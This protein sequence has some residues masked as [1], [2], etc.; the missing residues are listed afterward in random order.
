MSVIQTLVSGHW[1][2]CTAWT[3][4]HFIWEG[5]AIAAIYTV[6]RDRMLCRSSSPRSRYVLACGALGAMAI[7]PL[8]TWYLI[9]RPVE[10]VSAD[11]S[12]TLLSRAPDSSVLSALSLYRITPASSGREVWVWVVALWFSVSVTLLTRTMGG[13][14]LAM[15]L[16]ATFARSAPLEWCER[17]A[18]LSMHVGLR[19]SLRLSISPIVNVPT[20]M[21]WLRPVVLV[22]V[23]F[24]TGLPR[25]QVEAVLLH[26]LAH[27]RRNDYLVNILQSIAEALLFYH[28]AVWW[29][30][31][32]IRTER[33]LCCD[34][35]AVSAGSD[36]FSYARAL[37]EL[38]LTG[39]TGL[40]TTL[41]VTGG[42][43]AE[44]IERLLALPRPLATP[45]FSKAGL[46]VTATLIAGACFTLF[47]SLHAQ[48]QPDWQIAAGGKMQFEVASVK[49][50]K[51]D[52]FSSLFPLSADDSYKSTGGRFSADFPLV[53]YVQFA[54]RLWMTPEQ[55]GAMLEQ[56][57]KWAATDH[58]AIEARAEGNPTKDQMRLM[59]QS[60][61]ADRFKLAM[62]FETRQGKVLAL[63]LVTTGKTGPGLRPHADGPQ[64]DNDGDPSTPL[65]PAKPTD[66]FPQTCGNYA[67]VRKANGERQVGSRNTTLDLLADS[68]PILGNLGRTV[69]NRT[70]LSG[71]FDFVMEYVAESSGPEAPN[72]LDLQ[73]PTFLQALHDQ[74]GLKL[75]STEG[76]IQSVVVDHVERPSEN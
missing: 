28:P 47:P 21:G 70:G 71:R 39:R 41:A 73:G 6:A 59:M 24:L 43:V 46:V 29:I 9:L 68:L 60:L 74:L 67:M 17:I 11:V 12:H 63:S 42:S 75:E 4:I 1:V 18:Q 7:A 34:D 32:H 15:R 72:P 33:E 14:V 54:Y 61:L 69:I 5:A 38:A 64:C 66:T 65:E 40:N 8:L 45:G 2:E 3:L 51:A 27:I 37:T 31:G 36:P 52:S 25:D 58:Y 49:A 26:E 44:R 48:G 13:A 35:I 20:V 30:S 53:S 76:P 50:S 62:H 19:S 56:M 55:V 10:Q 22:P 57:P 16:R 23:G